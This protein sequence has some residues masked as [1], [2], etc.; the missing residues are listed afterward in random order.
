VVTLVQAQQRY[1]DRLLH[2]HPGHA[3]RVRR[4]ARR[5]LWRWASVRGYD[6]ATVVRDA[7]DMVVLITRADD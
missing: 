6:P 7:H 2:C 3:R 4:A 1:V 5:T